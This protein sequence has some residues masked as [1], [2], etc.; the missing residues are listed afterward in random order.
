MLATSN[1]IAL[2]LASSVYNFISKFLFVD[3]EQ[4]YPLVT[5]TLRP[6]NKHL[7]HIV[8]IRTTH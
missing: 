7:M 5:T 6:E 1:I 2:N 4:S 3:K 8:I